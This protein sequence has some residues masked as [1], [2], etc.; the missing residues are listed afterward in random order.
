MIV[1][2]ARVNTADAPAP[3]ASNP[4][5]AGLLQYPDFVMRFEGCE[6]AGRTY[7]SDV[8]TARQRGEGRPKSNPPYPP[9]SGGYKKAMRPRRAEGVLLFLAPLTRGGRGG[10]L[11]GVYLSRGLL[12]FNKPPRSRLPRNCPHLPCVSRLRNPVRSAAPVGI[13]RRERRHD[14]GI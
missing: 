6:M 10:C 12:S 1:E 14:R 9:L 2:S 3:A 13:D 8:Y 4:P 5:A 11:Y 7:M